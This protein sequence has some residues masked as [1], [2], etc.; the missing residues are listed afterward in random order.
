MLNLPQRDVDGKFAPRFGKTW[1][2]KQAKKETAEQL[3]RKALMASESV[4]AW[5][6]EHNVPIEDAW[7]W[8]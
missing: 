5:C 2:K 3:R 8:F 7:M 6:A 4:Q 1:A